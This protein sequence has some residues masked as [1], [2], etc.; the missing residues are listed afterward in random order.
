MLADQ[1]Q[2]GCEAVRDLVASRAGVG[3]MTVY[4]RFGERERLIDTLDRVRDELPALAAR[5]GAP[6]AGRPSRAAL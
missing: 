4:R 5:L 1:P 3:R 2:R 6:A